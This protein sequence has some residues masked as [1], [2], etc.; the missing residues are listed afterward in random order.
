MDKYDFSNCIFN[1]GGGMV[2]NFDLIDGYV[3]LYNWSE[4]P[5]Y[6]RAGLA[7]TSITLVNAVSILRN[8]N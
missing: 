3:F 2:V 4:F 7:K 8:S 1:G 5:G 6:G